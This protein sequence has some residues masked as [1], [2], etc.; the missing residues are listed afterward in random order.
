MGPINDRPAIQMEYGF[1]PYKLKPHIPR[2]TQIP[3][4]RSGHRIVSDNSCMYSF[5]GFNPFVEG[6]DENDD[7]KLFKEIWKFNIAK[8]KWKRMNCYSSSLP[9]QLASNCVLMKGNWMI[10]HGGTG[11]PFGSLNTNKTYITDLKND[12][13]LKLLPTLGN[14]PIPQY[15]QAMVLIGHC[16]YVVGGTSGHEYSSDVH[17]LDIKTGIWEEVYIS[18]GL[19]NLEPQGRYR[20]E[21]AFYNSRII[22]FGGGTEENVFGFE[23]LP[24]FNIETKEWETISTT[25]N[26]KIASGRFYNEAFPAPR[27]CHSCV[28]VPES[29]LQD[30]EVVICGGFNG[31]AKFYDIWILNLRTLQWRECKQNLL[32]PTYFHSSSLSPC[33]QMFIFGG[34]CEIVAPESETT[35][36][37]TNEIFSMWVI[38]PKLK[39]ICWEALLFYSP[40]I[41]KCSASKLIDS[42]VP[43]EFV[44]R[45]QS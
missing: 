12:T 24:A 25:G 30:S 31:L 41:T 26:P 23:H 3:R 2:N 32:Y 15:G 21:V 42:G 5:G 27:R 43:N 11:L 7:R 14:P 6:G 10:V 39:E 9:R 13:R 4:G 29:D 33:G 19:S 20:H 17:C 37:R 36:R 18:K 28:Q 22:I 1:K 8:G 44:E 45:L 34:I 16:L 35:T 40:N 38:I